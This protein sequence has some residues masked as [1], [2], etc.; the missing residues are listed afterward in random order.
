MWPWDAGRGFLLHA[1]HVC[2]VSSST[3][4]CI[5]VQLPCGRLATSPPGSLKVDVF[6]T[7]VTVQKGQGSLLTPSMV[8][9]THRALSA[10]LLKES[11]HGCSVWG[12]LWCEGDKSASPPRLCGPG[13]VPGFLLTGACLCL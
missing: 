13:Q 10:H 8:Q 4:F 9:G 2:P 1:C 5:S 11:R 12:T 7:R 3:A 6:C